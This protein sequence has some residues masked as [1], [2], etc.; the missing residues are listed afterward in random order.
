MNS[1][2]LVDIARTLVGTGRGLLAIDESTTTCTERR[3]KDNSA[4]MERH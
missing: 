1:Q 4:A 3:F 2:A